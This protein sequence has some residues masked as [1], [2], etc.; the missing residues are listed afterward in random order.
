MN[1]SLRNIG[2]FFAGGMVEFLRM[3]SGN[4]MSSLRINSAF[5]EQQ[6]EY[7]GYNISYMLKMCAVVENKIINKV[8]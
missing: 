6:V 1:F 3:G 8:G 5:G 4:G 7:R 2:A